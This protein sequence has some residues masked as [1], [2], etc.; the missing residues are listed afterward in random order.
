MMYSSW[1]I[2]CDR[3]NFLSSWAIFCPLIQSKFRKNKKT[4][5]DIIILHKC[6]INDMVP[7][8]WNAAVFFVI[9]GHFLPFFTIFCHFFPTTNRK[10]K[11]LKEWKKCLGTSSFYTSVTKIMIICYTVPEIWCMGYVICIFHF[12]LFFAL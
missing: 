2:E 7:E 1:D 10:N 9:L 12:G 11:I 3:H 5:G 8:I 4:S 6:I